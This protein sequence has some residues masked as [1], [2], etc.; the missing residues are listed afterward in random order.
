MGTQIGKFESKHLPPGFH[1]P[2]D[3][4]A[5]LIANGWEE[6]E[7]FTGGFRNNDGPLRGTVTVTSDPWT[8][9][10]ELDEDGC[11]GLILP[12]ITPPKP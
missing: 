5:L 8:A 11:F 9:S 1:V 12:T 2:P 3:V 10:V 4:A 7:P 6:P